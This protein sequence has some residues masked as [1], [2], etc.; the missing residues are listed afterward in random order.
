MEQHRD[1]SLQRKYL[2]SGGEV[3]ERIS[4]LLSLRQVSP[5]QSSCRRS[6]MHPQVAFPV[7]ERPDCGPSVQTSK[8]A[9][10]FEAAE[11]AHLTDVS[12]QRPERDYLNAARQGSLVAQFRLEAQ[13]PRR[14]NGSTQRLSFSSRYAANSM[15]AQGLVRI[16]RCPAALQPHRQR[17]PWACDTSSI[18]S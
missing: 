4:N 1:R 6:R 13:A 17:R 15:A 7:P 8:S 5:P 12:L 11:G 18:L 14:L 10:S 3:S 9:G 2:N 16:R